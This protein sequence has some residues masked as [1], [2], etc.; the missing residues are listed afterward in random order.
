MIPNFKLMGVSMLVLATAFAGGCSNGETGS[1]SAAEETSSAAA[2][3]ET[4]AEPAAPAAEEPTAAEETVAA[5]EEP[6]S[7]VEETVAEAEEAEEMVMADA[8]DAMASAAGATAAAMQDDAGGDLPADHPALGGDAAKGKRVFTKCMS[9]HAVKE[10][11]NRVGPSLYGIIGREA[12][13][14]AGFNYS[15]A[16]ANSGIVWTKDVL[17]EYLED[18]RGYL[19]GTKM[20]FPGLPSEQD[21]RDVI[22]YL[23]SVAEGE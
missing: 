7:A 13:T 20:V 18:P 8:S 9:C 1:E 11:Q 12:G 23:E 21:R 2:A 17:F 22:A 3:P 5:A 10:G 14:V 4:A 16:N 19:P 6:A 15:D